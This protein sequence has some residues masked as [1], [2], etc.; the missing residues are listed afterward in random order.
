MD[1]PIGNA[2]TS[3]AT[4]LNAVLLH[5]PLHPQLAH[6]NALRP[7]LPPDARP[8]IRA[9]ILR[10]DGAD[11]NQQCFVAEVPAL[12]NIHTPRQVFTDLARA[13]RIP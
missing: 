10:I 6:A 7:Q 8:S 12:G 3:L 13:K 5:Q 11:V 1:E 4:R 9:A 2:E